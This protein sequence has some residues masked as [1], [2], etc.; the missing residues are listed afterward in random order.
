MKVSGNFGMASAFNI[1]K[2][3]SESCMGIA[4]GIED[5]MGLMEKLTRLT[6][7]QVSINYKPTRN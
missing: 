6:L 5:Q 3:F 1:T 7:R 2:Y 4:L